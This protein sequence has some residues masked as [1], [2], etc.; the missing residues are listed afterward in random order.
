MPDSE[1]KREWMK[2]NRITITMVLMKRTENDIIKKLNDIPNKS[3]YIKSLI[4]QDIAKD[5]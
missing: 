3:G 1:A 4:R 2:K 5:K